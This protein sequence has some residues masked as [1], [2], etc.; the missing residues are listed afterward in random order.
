[1]MRPTAP[2]S[3]ASPATTGRPFRPR[4]AAAGALGLALLAGCTT[5]RD[6]SEARDGGRYA[7]GTVASV[8]P[9][10]VMFDRY[11]Y[12]TAPEAVVSAEIPAG[13]GRLG[14]AAGTRLV[15]RRVDDARA[16]CTPIEA[17]FACFYDDDGD[18]AFDH[19]LVVNLGI[20]GSRRDLPAPAAYSVEDGQA[21]RGYKSEL[22]YEGLA[23]T[24]IRLRYR[25]YSSEAAGGFERPT[26]E[27]ALE[28][29]LAPAGTPT[30]IGY[31]DARFKVLQA[32]AAGL[33][34]E[35]LS[36]FDGS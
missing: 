11:R 6:V 21:R 19:V 30:E 36:G 22:V 13:A 20:V 33:R 34:Y 2:A 10:E 4:L 17:S 35:I 28:F 27:Q 14:L 29:A 5:I 24:T 16:W 26:Y 25:D 8:R 15:A 32:D 1:M 3:S 18:R 9:G 7:V 12:D 23:G 31:R